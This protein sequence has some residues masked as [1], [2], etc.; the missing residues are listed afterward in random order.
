MDDRF[1]HPVYNSIRCPVD[2]SR[3]RQKSFFLVFGSATTSA[4][5]P[6]WS[7]IFSIILFLSTALLIVI[8]SIFFVSYLKASALHTGGIRSNDQGRDDTTRPHRQRAVFIGG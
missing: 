2:E 7:P 8:T 6:H 1:N 4:S 3:F 5:L